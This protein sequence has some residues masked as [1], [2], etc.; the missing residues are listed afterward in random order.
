MHTTGGVAREDVLQEGPPGTAQCT[1]KLVE[2]VVH[3]ALEIQVRTHVVRDLR[4]KDAVSLGLG[5]LLQDHVLEANDEIL[6]GAHL[7]VQFA[8]CRVQPQEKAQLQQ[9]EHIREVVHWM[10]QVHLLDRGVR[11]GARGRGR[12][13]QGAPADGLHVLQQ[14]AGHGE[15]LVAHV[16]PA[17]AWH[18]HAERR[19]RG[20]RPAPGVCNHTH[21]DTDRSIDVQDVRDTHHDAI[22]RH[23]HGLAPRG[24][25][26]G[27]EGVH[28][29]SRHYTAAVVAAPEAR[30]AGAIQV[31]AHAALRLRPL[32]ALGVATVL[33]GLGDSPPVKTHRRQATRPLHGSTALRP[34]SPPDAKDGAP[35]GSIVGAPRS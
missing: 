27:P 6:E 14:V 19:C 31:Y 35:A 10:L 16:H 21:D 34:H 11:D 18:D 32:A 15:D 5:V 20:I 22:A 3:H 2:D 13:L 26:V 9:E 23:L 30:D 12:G 33:G 28:V 4:L 1:L 25:G 8:A 29:P 17:Q 24:V 7:V